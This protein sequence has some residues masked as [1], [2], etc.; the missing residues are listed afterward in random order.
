MYEL[1][2]QQIRQRMDSGVA[3]GPKQIS[4]SQ[5]THYSFE[6]Q[7]QALLALDYVQHSLQLAELQTIWT[8]LGVGCEIRTLGSCSFASLKKSR[9]LSG[10]CATRSSCFGP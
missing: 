7:V 3:G 10:F 9:E 4:P 6:V 8:L 1:E 5:T 2:L